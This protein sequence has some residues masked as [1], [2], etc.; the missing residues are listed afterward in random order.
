MHLIHLRRAPQYLVDCVQLV[1]TATTR[2][3]RSSD[4]THYKNEKQ[5]RRAW[6]QLLWSLDQRH[7]IPFHHIFVQL[8]TL[9]PLNGT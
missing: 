8:L 9:M 2:Q 7:G 4:T 6:L 3:L 1:N 5:V